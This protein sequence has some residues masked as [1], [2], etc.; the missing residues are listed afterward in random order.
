MGAYG[1]AAQADQ[2]LSMSDRVRVASVAG[3][4]ISLSPDG[5]AA[6]LAEISVLERTA[7]QGRD[8]LGR[9]EVI[10]ARAEAP[11]GQARRWR[12]SG[13]ICCGAAVLFVACGLWVWQ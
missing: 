9:S 12:L 3:W 4:G 8:L 5:C 11:L 10:L 2:P 7:A 6:L 1:S 13:A